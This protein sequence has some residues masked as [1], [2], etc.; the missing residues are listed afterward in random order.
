MYWKKPGASS[1]STLEVKQ[2]ENE[3]I[4]QFSS[5]LTETSV[6]AQKSFACMPFTLPFKQLLPSS[7]LADYRNCWTEPHWEKDSLQFWNEFSQMAQVGAWLLPPCLSLSGE[8]NLNMGQF[9]PCSIF[10]AFLDWERNLLSFDFTSVPTCTYVGFGD[11]RYI[12]KGICRSPTGDTSYVLRSLK[13]TKKDHPWSWEGSDWWPH[14]KHILS[15][16][17]SGISSSLKSIGLLP[18]PCCLL[19]SALLEKG[20]LAWVKSQRDSWLRSNEGGYGWVSCPFSLHC[21][22]CS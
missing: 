21:Y 7:L 10:S 20:Q 8:M 18:C 2:R 12:W 5:F 19:S 6:S 22:K 11:M 15:F 1:S 4:S 3:H 17:H 9:Y 14:G 13:G 16:L